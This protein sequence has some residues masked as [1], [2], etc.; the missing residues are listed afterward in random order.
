M[1]ASSR[2]LRIGIW[3]PLPPASSGVADYVVESLEAL[4]AHADVFLVAEDAGRV[5]P[6]VGRRVAV[7]SHEKG[8]DDERAHAGSG[9]DV[10]Q[11]LPEW[12]RG[13]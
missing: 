6:A 1:T 9:R 8:L 3:S 7:H 10:V 2:R 4:I 5:D 11:D 13:A 12:N